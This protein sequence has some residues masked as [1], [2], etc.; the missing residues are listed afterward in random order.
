MKKSAL[1]NKRVGVLRVAFRAQKVL[2]AFEKRA[3]GLNDLRVHSI[4]PIL[5]QELNYCDL[6]WDLVE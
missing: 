4:D 3:P 2:G 6:P 5:E 1:Q